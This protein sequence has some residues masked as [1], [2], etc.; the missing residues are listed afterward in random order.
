M[1]ACVCVLVYEHEHE[2]FSIH[3]SNAHIRIPKYG[4]HLQRAGF[5]SSTHTH[6][7]VCVCVCVFAK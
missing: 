6:E 4:V 2:R 7:Y 5:M 1:R 3:A